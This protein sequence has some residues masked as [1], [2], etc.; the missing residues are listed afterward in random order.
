MTVYGID[1]FLFQLNLYIHS[2]VYNCN[3]STIVNRDG[4]WRSKW[5]TIVNF[6]VLNIVSKQPGW[7]IF[8]WYAH[9]RIRFFE[10][11][12]LGCIHIWTIQRQLH[13][14]T[15]HSKNQFII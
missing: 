14:I 9:L 11:F 5:R 10:D 7:K 1:K 12:F 15:Q 2:S 6:V 13:T 8:Q 4:A 3:K